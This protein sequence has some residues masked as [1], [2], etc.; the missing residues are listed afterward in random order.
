M[1]GTD[2]WAS[3]RPRPWPWNYLINPYGLNYDEITASNLVKI[4]D[5]AVIDDTP[6]EINHAGFV[7]HSAI[8]ETFGRE[9]VVMHTHTREGM[10]VAGTK[11]GFVD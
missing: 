2:I 9:P 5:G 4:D 3:H 7:I 1:D 8:H 11:W 10:A 6:F